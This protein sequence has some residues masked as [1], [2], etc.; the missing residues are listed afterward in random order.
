MFCFCT[1]L[2]SQ[3]LP[4]LEIKGLWIVRESMVSRAEI[5]KALQFAHDAGFNHVFVQVRGR[6][7]AYY[8][9]LI[10]PR[11]DRIRERDLDPLEYAVDKGHALGL[12]VHAW[13]TTYLLWSARRP[14]VSKAHLYHMHPEWLD[15]AAD[16]SAHRDIDLAAPRDG[17]FEGVFLSPVHPEVNNYLKAIFTE[18]LLNYSIDG[19]HLDYVRY[20][21]V[22]YGYNEAGIEVFRK[23]H[24]FDPRRRGSGRDLET[25]RS[26]LDLWHDFRRQK[27]TELV[28]S[29]HAIIT[30]G[31]GE[32]M[33]TAAVKPNSKVA[34]AKYGQDWALWL[35]N[36]MLDYALPMNYV[37]DRRIYL[38]NL[39]V[40][41]STLP[42]G[43]KDR[44]IMGVAVYNQS[45]ADAVD[46][47]ELA[48]LAGMR[49][50][51]IFSYD[52]H[53]TNLPYFDSIIEMLNR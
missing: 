11:A 12:N 41:L 16:G 6:G 42:R 29:L 15:V 50:I 26:Q 23:T 21:D 44:V 9:S 28:E 25:Q 39:R 24:L 14:P 8:R 31:R 53:K 49:A 36:D 48:R 20:F 3:Q 37:P 52:A 27:V 45:A 43:T 19:L 7:D 18:I 22:D 1:A 33:L 10:V 2:S 4:P 38:D 30:L 32:I 17:S 13:V 34:R 35:E 40:T 47:I 46:R 5:D 51:A